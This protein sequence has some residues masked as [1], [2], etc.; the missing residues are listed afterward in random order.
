MLVLSRKTDQ[1][2]VI[3]G[4]IRLT[5]LRVKGN[6][7][8]LGIEAPRDIR[9]VRGE[10]EHATTSKQE[11]NVIEASSNESPE[12]EAET[13]D[14]VTIRFAPNQPIQQTQAPLARH[15][16]KNSAPLIPPTDSKSLTDSHDDLMLS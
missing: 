12:N 2:V 15:I 13:S 14:A 1:E 9:I 7:V 10:L 3:G 4:N 8:R 16:K 6:T 5:V 11:V